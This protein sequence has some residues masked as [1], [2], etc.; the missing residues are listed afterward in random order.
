MRTQTQGAAFL[1]DGGRMGQ[2]VREFDWSQTALGSIENWPIAL[3]I[4]ASAMLN[5]RFPQAVIWGDSLI[6]LYNDAFAPILG[7]KPACLGQPFSQIWKEAWNSIGPIAERAFAGEATFIEDFELT[8]DRF[9]YPEQAFFTFCYSPLRD[10]FGN[11]RGFLDTVV[12][13]TGKVMAERTA[14]LL[15]SELA[16]RLQNTLALV[17]GISEQ[18]LRGAESINEAQAALSQRISALGRTHALLT[19]QSWDAASIRSIVES[20]LAAAPSVQQ[21]IFVRGPHVSLASR[22][23]LALA[24][25]LNELVT[26]AVKYGALSTPTG[27]L[28]VTWEMTPSQFRFTWTER[29]GPPVREPTRQGFGSRLLKEVLPKDFDGEVSIEYAPEGLRMTLLTARENLSSVHR[30]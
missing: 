1:V 20:S 23:S 6:T 4:S 5:S 14:R 7:R 10:E 2:A 30:E 12:E 27:Q 3:K 19:Q 11:V 25:A 13:T 9:G 29:N 18:T 26:N 17:M 28:F 21:E 22:Q 15:N 24:L 16:H 8:I